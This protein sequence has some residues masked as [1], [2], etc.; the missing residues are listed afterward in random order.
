M[1]IISIKDKSKIKNSRFHIYWF[2]FVICILGI[3]MFAGCSQ[4]DELHQAKKLTE[5]SS[6]YYN[7]AVDKYKKLIALGKDTDKLYFN[8]GRLYFNHG[9]FNEA[10]DAFKKSNDLEAKKFLAISNYRM[11][12]FTDALEVFNKY[13]NSDSEYLYFK[14]LTCEKLNLFDSALEDYKK[15]VNSEFTPLAIIRINTIEKLAKSQNIKEISPD[16][17]KLLLSAPKAEVYPQAGALILSCDEYIEETKDLREVSSL[18]YVIK[19]LN[20]RGKQDFSEAKIDYDS[21]YEKVELEYAR[22]IKPDGSIVEVGARHIRDVSK[23]LNF[24]L[25]SNARVYIISFPEIT[26]GA[27]IEYKLKIHCN[28][29]INNKDFVIPYPVQS[30]DPIIAANFAVSFPKSNPAAMKILSEAYNNFGAALKPKIEEKDGTVFY[31]WKF[32]DIP[33][34]ISEADMPPLVEINPSIILSSF[35]SWKDVYE[36]WWKLAKDKMLSDDQIK[37]KVKELTRGLAS[38]EEKLRA[39][40]NFC[41]QEIRYVAVEYGQAGYEPHQAKDIFRNKYGDCK[42][43]AILLVTMLR[44]AGISAW[45][46][47]ISTKDYFNLSEDFPS[48]LFNHC[49]ACVQ[50]KDKIIFM[51]PTAQTCP[52]GDLPDGDQDRAV[53]IC[54]E[55]GYKIARTPLFN[56]EHNFVKQ[57]TKI[58]IS[59]DESVFGEKE[60]YTGG[61]YNQGQR[62]WLLYTQPELVEAQLKER[63]QDFSIGAK[64]LNY[65]IKDLDDLN[66]PVV[67]EYSFSGPEYLT[68]AGSLR[69]MPQL[70]GLETSLVAKEKRTYPIEFSILDTKETIFEFEIP[71]TFKIKYIPENVVQDSPWMEFSAEYNNTGNILSFRQKVIF[72]RNVISENEYFDFKKFYEGLAKKIKQRAVLERVK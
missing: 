51:D 43:Q 24:P 9:K 19:I 45:P 64:L 5:E 50:L 11:G 30:T 40:H 44:E 32:S 13:E 29:L 28:K 62:Y 41:A 37:N 65:K 68:P 21:T 34:I 54:Q 55:N 15:I 66:K 14:G 58:K 57:V 27:T 72:K 12:N 36:W 3:C 70:A 46:L 71:K 39:I 4:K 7:Q 31:R 20:E 48:M 18:H 38:E 42:D 1:H 47:L 22:T 53:L 8:L 60:I 33:Q 63:I 25:Y 67:L 69:I 56:P 2:L 52:F 17:Y 49:I 6:N 35:K 10:V 59:N 23:Y 16:V 26:D 61:V